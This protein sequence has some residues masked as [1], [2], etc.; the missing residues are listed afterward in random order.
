MLEAMCDSVSC[1]V[2]D[3]DQVVGCPISGHA[4]FVDRC[5][6]TRVP[7]SSLQE[8]N[9]K[10]S[11]LDFFVCSKHV[12]VRPVVDWYLS[13]S[14]HSAIRCHVTMR[15]KAKHRRPT[16]W[17]PHPEE[18]IEGQAAMLVQ[19][20]EASLVSIRSRVVALHHHRI[21]SLFSSSSI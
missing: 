1:S 13:I 15:A 19:G 7:R 12:N 20:I 18:D 17:N 9:E 11:L 5:F 4:S 14:D 3:F 16:N 2:Q 8:V 21:H 6:F 10:A